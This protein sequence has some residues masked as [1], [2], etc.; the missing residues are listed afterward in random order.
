MLIFRNSYMHP[1]LF[2]LPIGLY[3]PTIWQIPDCLMSTIS[4]STLWL[5]GP[6]T[7]TSMAHWS[8]WC[9]PPDNIV[10]NLQ[11]S[12]LGWK[13]RCLAFCL[14]SPGL[15][16]EKL[17]TVQLEQG[18]Y[19]EDAS[20][21]YLLWKIHNHENR[22][23]LRGAINWGSPYHTVPVLTPHIIYRFGNWVSTMDFI[24]RKEDEKGYL[25]TILKALA[26]VPCFSFTTMET[27]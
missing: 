13:V 16:E 10:I 27:C 21:S 18:H 25:H 8:H 19:V 6:W 14:L 24:S 3:A 9:Q 15:T 11:T 26:L 20:F 12:A 7:I 17:S 23:H 5:S 2:Q 4:M 1:I 22:C